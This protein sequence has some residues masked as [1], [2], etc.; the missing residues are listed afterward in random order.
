MLSGDVLQAA[1]DV[2]DAF[3]EGERLQVLGAD[4]SVP[5]DP[6]RT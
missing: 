6:R 1:V 3:L 5:D 2:W 4:M